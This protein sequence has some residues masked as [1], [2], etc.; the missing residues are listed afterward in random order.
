MLGKKHTLRHM[1]AT[2][3]FPIASIIFSPKESKTMPTGSD[4]LHSKS[5]HIDYESKD[6]VM[7]RMNSWIQEQEAGGKIHQIMNIETVQTN[8]DRY[9]KPTSEFDS[10]CRN[11]NLQSYRVWYR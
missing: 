8:V 9:C 5:Y 11:Y 4:V 3:F 10:G 6:D 2:A 7:K 1:A